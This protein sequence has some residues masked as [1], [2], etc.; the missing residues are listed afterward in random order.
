MTH[1]KRNFYLQRLYSQLIGDKL[2]SHPHF[3]FWEAIYTCIAIRQL[4]G[5]SGEKISPRKNITSGNISWFV[6]LIL[7]LCFLQQDERSEPKC[8]MC[9]D[10]IKPENCR[11]IGY[12]DLDEVN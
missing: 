10:V 4:L 11:T 5:Y 3:H 6:V 12:C 1:C 7:F 8:Y 2:Y 9:D